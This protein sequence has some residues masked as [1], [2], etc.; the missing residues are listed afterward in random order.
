MAQRA[1][2]QRSA[3]GSEASTHYPPAPQ[4]HV[5]TDLGDILKAFSKEVI[6]KQPADLLQFSAQ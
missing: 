3:R 4:I 2:A 6:R 1:L 5:P